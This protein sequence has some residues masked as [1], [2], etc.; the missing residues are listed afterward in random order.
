[1]THDLFTW[2]ETKRR[3]VSAISDRFGVRRVCDCNAFWLLHDP[4][5]LLTRY[6]IIPRQ[7]T[8]PEMQHENNGD[9]HG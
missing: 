2:A 1:M 7:S 3:H 9:H 8:W 4:K 6:T 5:A